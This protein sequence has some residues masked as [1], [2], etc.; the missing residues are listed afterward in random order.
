MGELDLSKAIEAADCAME[1]VGI[2]DA[3]F[4]KDR[5]QASRLAVR[6]ALPHVLEALAE[7]ASVEE[8]SGYDRE[9]DRYTS[10]KAK[11]AASA[12]AWLRD[13]AEEARA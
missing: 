9:D 5:Q 10:R 3:L 4:Q 13:K 2:D 12:R 6:A 7:V 8:L 11:R 1:G